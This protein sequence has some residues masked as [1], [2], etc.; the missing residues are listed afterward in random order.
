MRAGN[1]GIDTRRLVTIGKVTRVHG[2]CGEV[3]VQSLSDVPGRF[4]TLER[5]LVVDRHGT[6]RELAVRAWRRAGG[7]YLLA[8]DGITTPEAAASLV[9]G[10]LQIAAEQSAPLPEGRYFEHDL[11]RMTVRTEDGALVGELTE[12]LPTGANAVFVVIG[13][14][15]KEQLIPAT[16]EVV[17]AVDVPGRLMTIRRIAGLLDDEPDHAV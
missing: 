6:L 1:P 12:I 7:D 8:F 17:R 4:E 11:L 16:R 9:G 3:R 5:V 2:L 15:G 14:T 10:W 13:A